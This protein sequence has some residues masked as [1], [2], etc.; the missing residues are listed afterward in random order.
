MRVVG[1]GRHFGNPW[2]LH[3]LENMKDFFTK[4]SRSTSFRFQRL[5]KLGNGKDQ[6][7]IW[8]TISTNLLAC[9]NT[10]LDVPMA[11]R[12]E[13]FFLQL[14]DKCPEKLPG[15][16]VAGAEPSDKLNFRQLIPS[17]C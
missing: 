10:I 4:D 7:K 13:E 8:K 17:S 2:A 16:V 11:N 5:E 9:R 6:K 3:Y 15:E 1:F 12:S 14:A